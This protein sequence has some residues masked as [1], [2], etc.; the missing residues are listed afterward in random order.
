MKSL[1]QQIGVIKSAIKFDLGILYKL[2]CMRLV[3]IT[4]KRMQIS[5]NITQN[6]PQLYLGPTV[7]YFM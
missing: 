7:I 1:E 2:L 3:F 5:Q 4:I 6:E